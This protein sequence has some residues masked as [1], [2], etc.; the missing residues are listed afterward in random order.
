MNRLS[1]DCDWLML[2]VD[3]MGN[4]LAVQITNDNLLN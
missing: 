2:T 1:F 4:L 3:K